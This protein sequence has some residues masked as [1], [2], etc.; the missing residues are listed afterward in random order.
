MEKINYSEAYKSLLKFVRLIESDK[1]SY[2][3]IFDKD[4]KPY[5]IDA[6]FNINTNGDYV[7]SF[8]SRHLVNLDEPLWEAF[9]EYYNAFFDSIDVRNRTATFNNSKNEPNLYRITTKSFRSTINNKWETSYICAFYKYDHNVFNPDKSCIKMNSQPSINISIGGYEIIIFWGE[10]KAS[11]SN[12][13]ERYLTFI[14]QSKTSLSNFKKIVDTI[15][16]AWG[17]IT[18][19]YIGKS[20]YYVSANPLLEKDCVSFMYINLQE[21]LVTYR[22][23]LDYSSYDEI[24]SQNLNLTIEEFERLVNLLYKNDS[25]YR[26][27]QLLIQASHDEGLSKG[28]VAAIALETITGEIEKIRKTKDDSKNNL[29]MSPELLKELRD[30][31]TC[32]HKNGKITVTQY[33]HYLK[34]LNTFSTPFNS[35]KLLVPFQF[36]NIV[37]TPSEKNVINNRN[38]ILHGT[39]PRNNNNSSFA[40]K[41]NE[42]ELIFYASN[43]LIMLCSML[44]FGLANIDKLIID[45]GVTIVVKKRYIKGGKKIIG[46]GKRL[47]QILDTNPRDESPDWLL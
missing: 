3:I 34:K 13:D 19:Y 42:N 18:G 35:N 47:R 27:G 21:E 39:L 12:T 10:G 31:I 43:K 6:K 26:A 32:F 7:L 15:R 22:G 33:E 44:L 8:S 37:L 14:S 25:L 28:G 45:W 9:S 24:P 36:L 2:K 5:D 17:L 16:V 4:G 11:T 41:L 30:R 46:Y 38:Y 23:L 20:V 40:S 1:P 29:K